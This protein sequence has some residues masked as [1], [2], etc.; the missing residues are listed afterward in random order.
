MRSFLLRARPTVVGITVVAVLSIAGIATANRAIPDNSINT[1]DIKDNQVNTRDLR[2]GTITTRD[3]R[4]NQINTKD[5]RDGAIRGVDVHDGAIE[6]VDL[7]AETNALLNAGVLFDARAHGGS[8][9][10]SWPR[11]PQAIAAAVP[12][13]ADPIPKS[14]DG[15]AW[16][17][18]VLD[19][20][21]YLVQTTGQA[22]KAGNGAEAAATRLF[23]G[24]QPAGDGGGYVFFPVSESAYPVSHS[25]ATVIEVGNG[26]ED[27]RRLVQRVISLGG[28]VSLNDNLLVSKVTPR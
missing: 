1:R 21:T 2:N 26:N 4:D 5:L 10:L 27:Q 14:G 6:P 16:R 20:G 24:G 15:E 22:R 9:C 3:V 25:S 13:S 23:V 28:P 11:G 17:T 18:A 7:S 19:P 8:C 12:S